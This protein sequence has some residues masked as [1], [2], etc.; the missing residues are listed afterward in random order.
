MSPVSLGL[1]ATIVASPQSCGDLT[2]AVFIDDGLMNKTSVVTDALSPSELARLKLAAGLLL[3]AEDRL[4]V[5]RTL[6]WDRALAEA[7]FASGCTQMPQPDY[8]KRDVSAAR[9]AVKTAR[10]LIN[11]ASPVHR[12]LQRFADVTEETGALL[13]AV[14][15]KQF[16]VHSTRLYGAPL[17]LIADG[18]RTA[19]DLALRLDG[20]LATFAAGSRRLEPPEIL[21]AQDLKLRLDRELPS[22]F[23]ADAPRVEVARNVSGKAAASREAI[24][25]RADALFSDVDVTQLLQH[26]ALV[27]IAT[28]KNGAAQPH[29]PLLGESYPGNARTQEGLAVFAEFI[30]GA[31][32][33]M[34][35]KRLA[36]RVIA[37]QKSADGANFIEI[38]DY[39]LSQN[40]GQKVDAFESARRVVRGGLVE[41][42][43]PFT[44]DAVYLQGLLEV[45]NYLRTVVRAGDASYIRLLF[46]GKIDLADLDAM[47]ML[48]S[49]GLLA[50]P[51]FLPP[52]AQDLRYLLST[53]AY[54]TFLNEINL[55]E[56]AMR[57]EKLMKD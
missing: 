9:E 3:D 39:F 17:S 4:P 24:R 15:A 27:H 25:L 2:E 10:A 31:V 22:H 30:S 56:V 44:K 42:G 12:W 11:G 29:F 40:G 49:A 19:L 20:L 7:F 38:Y 45:H 16:L 18:R 36:D 55:A 51:K 13:Q 35:F 33:P 43:A 41:G 6:S 32:D 28:A 37:I 5:L 1:I 47:K 54:S 53:L 57:Y 8:P 48:R 14:G 26:E 50:E 23:G 46:V 52:W 34:R 21:S